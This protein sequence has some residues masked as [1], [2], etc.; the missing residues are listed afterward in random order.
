MSRE[1]RMP[2]PA[3]QS[4]RAWTAAW[5]LAGC[6]AGATAETPL[7]WQDLHDAAWA[8]QPEAQ[9]A[10]VWR[11]ALD[12]QRRAADAWTPEPP[13]LEASHRSDRLN[14]NAGARETEIGVAV[15]LW[16]PG[17]RRGR[18][19]QAEADAAVLDSRTQAARWRLAG[20]LRETAWAW[21]RARLDAQITRD[22]LAAS[23]RLAADVARRTRAGDLARADQHQA[24]AARA[25][26][27]A[28]VAQAEAAALAA[29]LRL[30]ALLGAA[31]PVSATAALA[32][33]PEPPPGEPP[34]HP[35][36]R[37]LQDRLVQAE[38]AAALA[39]LQRRANPEL[40]WATTRDRGAA[41]ERAAQTWVLGLR[42]PLGA[43]PAADARRARAQAEALEARAALALEQARLAADRD[44]ARARYEA[45]QAQLVASERRATLARETRGFFEKSFRLGETDLPTRL[46]VEA[47]ALEAERAAARSRIERAE[48]LSAW[49]QALGLLPE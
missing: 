19:A 24:E 4:L 18:A 43:G 29:S 5:L 25:A 39:A 38:R 48:A 13:A 32:D 42:L 3:L 27:Q 41:G 22:Q 11:E 14:G 34:L 21:Q 9:A 8:R 36:L 1:H 49:R 20:A 7:R 10:P 35:A 44:A 47:E 30:Q 6:A 46:R 28:A 17:E 16:L 12:A 31:L 15:P 26:A 40:T 2:A 45:A 23:E 33:E 37:E